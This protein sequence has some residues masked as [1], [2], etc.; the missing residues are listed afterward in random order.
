M[1]EGGKERNFFHPFMQTEIMILGEAMCII[2]YLLLYRKRA[3]DTS[4]K[5][6]SIALSIVPLV[7]D[8]SSSILIFIAFNYLS[9]SVYSLLTGEIIVFTA[10][11]S[12]IILKNTVSRAQILGSLITIISPV[13]AGV[14]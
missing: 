8:L 6:A 2:P 10:I 13:L 3:A 14:G 7:L 9:G 11:F 5:P 1:E 4:K 12:K